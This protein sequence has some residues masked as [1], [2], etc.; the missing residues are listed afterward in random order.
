MPSTAEL[1]FELERR[2][3]L[4][5]SI[6]TL[7]DG[8]SQLG[9]DDDPNLI[10]TDPNSRTDGE[11]L[12]YAAPVGTRYQEDNGTQWYKRVLPNTWEQFG[13]GG[14]FRPNRTNRT[15]GANRTFRA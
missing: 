13:V 3:I 6:T 11:S 14:A 1:L 7:E 9:Y 15:S 8:V 10:S 2:V 12:L 5:K 4:F